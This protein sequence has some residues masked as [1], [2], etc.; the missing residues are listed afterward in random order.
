M[1]LVLC[2]MQQHRGYWQE[3]EVSALPACCRCT[4]NTYALGTGSTTCLPCCKSGTSI[5]AGA[6][7]MW[8]RG[9]A[10]ATKF[11]PVRASKRLS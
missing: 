2:E 3:V 11:V 1:R 5:A 4:V 9:Q 8:T 7:A 10:G 6:C